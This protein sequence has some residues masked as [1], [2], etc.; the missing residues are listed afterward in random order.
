MGL[1]TARNMLLLLPFLL[2]GCRGDLREAGP[3][4]EL[5]EAYFRCRVQP[6]LTKDCSAFGCHGDARR[7]FRVFARNRLRYG[8]TEEERNA[9]LRDSERA[10][11]FDSARAMVSATD[12]D[13]SLLL[14]KPLNQPAGGYYHGARLQG[15]TD[16]FETRDDPEFKILAA[17]VGGA[18]EDPACIEP[19]SDF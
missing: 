16:V 10:A 9:F 5:D 2:I 3:L 7:Y 11:N 19:G 6:V 18:K 14:L 4:P 15:T 17:W 8:G 13:S 1:A 12:P